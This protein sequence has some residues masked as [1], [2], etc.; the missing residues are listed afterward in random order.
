GPSAG[1]VAS[2]RGAVHRP[3]R[4]GGRRPRRHRRRRHSLLALPPTS[5]ATSPKEEVHMKILHT[6]DWHIGKVLKG[7]S[8]L[9]EQIAVLA[10]I[11][12]IAEDERPDLV[13]VAGDLFD[14]AAPNADTEKV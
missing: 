11:V 3:V 4:R 12:A 7:Q 1:R 2:L 14:T 13:I 8:R 9:D 10:D 6:S 5:P